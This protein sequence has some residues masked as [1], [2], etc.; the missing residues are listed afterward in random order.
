LSDSSIVQICQVLN[1]GLKSK[2]SI[3]W[4]CT[5]AVVHYIFD[6]VD[7][8]SRFNTKNENVI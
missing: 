2:C 3:S 5:P 7:Q 8:V 4:E 6:L 1:V